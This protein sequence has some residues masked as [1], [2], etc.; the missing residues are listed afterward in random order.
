M[1]WDGLHKSRK[2]GWAEG[3]LACDL[4]GARFDPLFRG[5]FSG[6]FLLAPLLSISQPVP[7]VIP[8]PR[9]FQIYGRFTSGIL[10]LVV[11]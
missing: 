11:R 9:T 3:R 8:C 1:A 10:L 6:R 2:G 4:G 5:A 7:R